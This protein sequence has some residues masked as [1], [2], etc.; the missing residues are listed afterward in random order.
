MLQL[1]FPHKWCGWK[2]LGIAPHRNESYDT[3]S[4]LVHKSISTKKYPD[5]AILE[6]L[7]LLFIL[8]KQL[9][10][11][12]S[13]EFYFCCRHVFLHLRST[14]TQ[15][16]SAQSE[17]SSRSVNF[18]F[19]GSRQMFQ[20]PS[21]EAIAQAIQGSLA[22]SRRTLKAYLLIWHLVALYRIAII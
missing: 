17:P 8:S 1:I 13:V 21:D 16:K 5:I 10:Q 15:G 18:N 11:V 7:W 3:W 4:P 19:K 20:L 6:S 14:K 9:V 22:V 12:W 2:Q